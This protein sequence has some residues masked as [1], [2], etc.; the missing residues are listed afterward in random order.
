MLPARFKELSV[1]IL[2]ATNSCSG[3]ALDFKG[4]IYVGSSEDQAVIGKVNGEPVVIKCDDP[5]MDSMTCTDDFAGL[6]KSYDDVIKQCKAW[7]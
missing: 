3:P 4:T 6:Q 2:L 7:K 5:K 1:L